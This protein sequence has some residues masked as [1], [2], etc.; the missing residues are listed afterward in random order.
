M[1]WI[2]F[3]LIDQRAL[4]DPKR[5]RRREPVLM[6]NAVDQFLVLSTNA[7]CL[8]PKGLAAASPS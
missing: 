6:Q 8:I 2:S 4:F 7:R 3:G 1:P 5:A